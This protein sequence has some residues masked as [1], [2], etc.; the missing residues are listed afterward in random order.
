MQFTTRELVID[1]AVLILAAVAWFYTDR[2]AVRATV[3]SAVASVA[4]LF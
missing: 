4:G 1:S 2:E 3:Q